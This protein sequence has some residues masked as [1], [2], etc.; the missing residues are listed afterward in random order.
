MKT[1]GLF[2]LLFFVSFG[3]AQNQKEIWIKIEGEQT[4]QI[5]LDKNSIEPG[6]SNDVTVWVM[7]M[8]IPPLH[9]E[10][11][12]RKIYKSKTEYLFNTKLNRYGILKIIYFDAKGRKLK[13]FNYRVKTKIPDYRYSYPIFNNSIEENILKTIY[14]YHPNLNPYPDNN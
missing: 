11:V 1:L 12:N 6:D 2:F 13:S 9:I 14:R 3:Y 7:Q 8:H 10:S 5:Y 4:R